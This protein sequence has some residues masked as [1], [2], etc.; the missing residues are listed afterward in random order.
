M[1]RL[2]TNTKLLHMTV[3]LNYKKLRFPV[4]ERPYLNRQ[5]E[6]IPST[7]TEL[8]IK[9]IERKHGWLILNL[10]SD[11]GDMKTYHQIWQEERIELDGSFKYFDIHLHPASIKQ[12]EQFSFDLE[13]N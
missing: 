1:L 4:D 10:I 8:V 7:K 2:F 6:F 9:N 13:L 12:D 3:T 5:F 11:T